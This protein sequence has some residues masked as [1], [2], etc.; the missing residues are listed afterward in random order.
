MLA[1][2]DV[3]KVEGG[4]SQV[5]GAILKLAFDLHGYN[6]ERAGLDARRDALAD[7]L[8]TRLLVV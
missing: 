6:L 5:I 3:A 2:T 8:E 1:S 4:M 7:L